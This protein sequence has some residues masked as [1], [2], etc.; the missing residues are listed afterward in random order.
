MHTFLKCAQQCVAVSEVKRS[1]RTQ[2]EKH[3][4]YAQV[5]NESRPFRKNL[6]VGLELHV[7]GNSRIDQVPEVIVMGNGAFG[8]IT[9]G[10]GHFSIYADKFQYD[11]QQFGVEVNEKRVV[12]F[13][14]RSDVVFVVHEERTVHVGR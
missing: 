9:V 3:V 1:F 12:P 10:E 4:S 14:D 8:D 2:V 13:K 11:I 6:I 7:T 5:G